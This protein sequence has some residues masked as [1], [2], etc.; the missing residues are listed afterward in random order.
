MIMG[1]RFRVYSERTPSD[2]IFSPSAS[3]VQG[4]GFRARVSGFERRVWGVLGED[5]LGLRLPPLRVA[6]RLWV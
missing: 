4:S 6:S 1:V 3:R 5:A 2:F